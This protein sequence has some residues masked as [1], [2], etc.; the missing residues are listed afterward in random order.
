M[1]REIEQDNCFII[2]QI[3]IVYHFHN[4]ENFSGVIEK[5]LKLA[6]NDK[7]VKFE[8]I[9]VN[10]RLLQVDSF[11]NSYLVMT[12]LKWKKNCYLTENKSSPRELK[13]F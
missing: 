4:K 1:F 11:P 6:T 8:E 5:R 2:Q 13:S 10:Y 7:H 9:K 12:S 3:L